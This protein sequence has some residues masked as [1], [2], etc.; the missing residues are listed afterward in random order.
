MINRMMR[1]PLRLVDSTLFRLWY[2]K[3]RTESS[4]SEVGHQSVSRGDYDNRPGA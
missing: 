3:Q 4:F 2:G 1:V